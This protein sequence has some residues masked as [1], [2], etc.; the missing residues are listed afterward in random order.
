MCRLEGIDDV[1]QQFRVRAPLKDFELARERLKSAISIN[2][3]SAPAIRSRAAF[4]FDGLCF[5]D[6]NLNNWISDGHCLF[7]LSISR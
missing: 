2:S 4:G 6:K 7:V 5:P 1:P 3:R